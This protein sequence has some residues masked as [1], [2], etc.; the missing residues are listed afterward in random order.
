MHRT[1]IQSI[2][3]LLATIAI[4]A[5]LAACGG[6]GGLSHATAETLGAWLELAVADDEA[7][8]AAGSATADDPEPTGA[9]AGAEIEVDGFDGVPLRVYYRYED[10]GGA[11]HF[12]DRI[13]EIPTGAR[14][15]AKRI[16]IRQEPRTRAPTAV[17]GQAGG[18]GPAWVR[19]LAQPDPRRRSE[20][21]VVI[22]TT[23]WCGWCRRTRAFLDER[24]VRY[25]DKNIEANDAYRDELIRK[26]GRASIPVVEIGGEL[27]RGYNERAMEALL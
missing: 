12:V 24:G 6:E 1:R 21:E 17:A 7:A 19:T 25:M 15:G 26:T 3:R 22:Y 2:E 23:P 5:G 10:A 27:I 11:M 13:D 14:A 20:P 9:D 4:S 16:E 18:E 8:P